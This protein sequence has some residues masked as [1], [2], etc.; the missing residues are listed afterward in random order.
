MAIARDFHVMMPHTVTVFGSSTMDKYGKQSYSG[1]GT[2]Y[3]CRVIW[4]QR[5]IRTTDNREILEAGRAIV[6]GVAVVDVNDRITIPGGGSPL[7]TS[8][9]QIKDEVGDHHTVIGFGA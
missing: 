3:R 1:T 2:P 5:M 6:Y 4:D 9:A 7:V 8:V